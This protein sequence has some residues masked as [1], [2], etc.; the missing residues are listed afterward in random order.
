MEMQILEAKHFYELIKMQDKEAAPWCS[1][2]L[3]LLAQPEKGGRDS[4]LFLRKRSHLR[5]YFLRPLV[6][7]T[8]RLFFFYSKC[9]PTSSTS[10][11]LGNQ[12]Q[13]SSATETILSAEMLPEH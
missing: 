8:S 12:E 2:K 9:Q 11:W 7:F 4:Q 5:P 3:S 6:T 1:Q 10:G 13:F